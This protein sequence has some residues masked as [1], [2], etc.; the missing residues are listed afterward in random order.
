[1]HRLHRPTALAASLAILTSLAPAPA[2]ARGPDPVIAALI[3]AGATVIPIAVGTT[4]WTGGRG[5]DEGIRFDL[6]LAFFALGGLVGPSTG[7]IYAEGGG[8]AW[9][10]FFLR[11]VTGGVGLAGAGMWARG[12]KEGT[13][14]AGQA[15]TFVGGVPAALLAIYDIADAA[16]SARQAQR[17]RGYGPSAAVAPARGPIGVGVGLGLDLCA[18]LAPETRAGSGGPCGP[19]PTPAWT[20]ALSPRLAPA[21]GPDRGPAPDPTPT[22]AARSWSAPARD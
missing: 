20:L 16:S 5:L 11:L 17:R 21:P 10:T 8:N 18:A 3:S 14:D 19:P 13:R 15:L 22:R 6:G 1:M 7:Q 9:V 4:M 2:E 12:Q